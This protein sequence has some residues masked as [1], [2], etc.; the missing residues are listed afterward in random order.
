MNQDLEA[1]IDA[2]IEERTT[3]ALLWPLMKYAAPIIVGKPC[4]VQ[5]Q[6][7][8]GVDGGL[9]TVNMK[10]TPVVSLSPALIDYGEREL[11]RV[12]LHELAHVKLHSHTFARSNADIDPPEYKPHLVN[13]TQEDQAD[14]Q[15]AEWLAYGETNR[16]FKD[17]YALGI[18]Y[19]L[20]N[21]YQQ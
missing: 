9:A 1:K 11:V 10:G 6:Q 18:I 15:T 16:N 14:N 12:Y 8:K 21:K 7:L 4:L 3:K 5:R 20:I 13:T 2:M 17:P 19:A